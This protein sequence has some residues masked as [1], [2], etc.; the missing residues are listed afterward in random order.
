MD[1]KPSVFPT[2]EQRDARQLDLDRIAAYE[3]EKAQV[4]NEIYNSVQVTNNLEG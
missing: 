2:Q 1:K 4:T 3:A